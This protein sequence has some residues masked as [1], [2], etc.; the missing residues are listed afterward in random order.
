MKLG[1]GGCS[2]LAFSRIR[3]TGVARS[4]Y[5]RTADP[6]KGA[7]VAHLPPSPR[8]RPPY[9]SFSPCLC[10]QCINSSDNN[11]YVSTAPC[12]PS[13]C[14]VRSFQAARSHTSNNDGPHQHQEELTSDF[15]MMRLVA[16]LVSDG[17]TELQITPYFRAVKHWPIKTQPKQS[18]RRFKRC[19]NFR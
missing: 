19:S 16:S 10:M 9:K 17:R 4:W 18:N 13:S 6:R 1:N 12:V 7:K 14:H 8:H 2:N 15:Q 5:A 11:L 3:A